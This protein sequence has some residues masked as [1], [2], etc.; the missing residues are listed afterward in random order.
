MNI[1]DLSM[2]QI[3]NKVPFF[4]GFEN[5]DLKIGNKY[6]IK[7][8]IYDEKY[9]LLSSEDVKKFQTNEKILEHIEYLYKNYKYSIPSERN[10][11]R[12]KQYFKALS[13]DELPDEYLFISNDREICLAKLELFILLMI[14]NKNLKWTD[15]M[16][17]WF[18]KSKQDSDLVLLKNWF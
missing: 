16:G 10:S 13:I 8:G 9:N 6:L 4:V 11:H 17:T 5:K 18:W 2:E 12:R 14:L 7:E 3:N 1:Y 15:D